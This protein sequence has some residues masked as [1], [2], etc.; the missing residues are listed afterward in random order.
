MLTLDQI[1]YLFP[2]FSVTCSKVYPVTER[3]DMLCKCICVFLFKRCPFLIF[4]RPPPPLSPMALRR[5]AGW[6]YCQH[7]KPN[8]I[9]CPWKTNNNNLINIIISSWHPLATFSDFISMLSRLFPSKDRHHCLPN[10][11]IT[12][13]PAKRDRH[14]F[15]S[16][17]RCL[18]G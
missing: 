16:P 17:L 9:V 15:S 13:H 14:R 11:I 6:F 18:S 1:G 5:S 3:Q 10:K 7:L 8:W 2:L 12:S 4:H